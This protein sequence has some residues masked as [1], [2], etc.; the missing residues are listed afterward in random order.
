MEDMRAILVHMN[1]FHIL[2][3]DITAKLRPFVDDEAPLTHL[4]GEIGKGRTE[5]TRADNQIIVFLHRNH[6]FQFSYKSKEKC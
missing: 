6:G 4:V 3:I 1:A 5:E 2:T